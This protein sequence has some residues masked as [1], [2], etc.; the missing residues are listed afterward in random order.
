MH[1]YWPTENSA[2]SSRIKTVYTQRHQRAV[3][4]YSST[5]VYIIDKEVTFYLSE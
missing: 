3:Y 1:I 4:E 2:S 5:Y